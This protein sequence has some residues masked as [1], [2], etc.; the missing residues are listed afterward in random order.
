MTDNTTTVAYTRN[1]RGSQSLD[2]NE[3]ARAIWLWCLP[4]E[5]WL[6]VSHIPGKH[7]AVA[8][9]ASTSF[10]DSKKWKLDVDIFIKLSADGA[11]QTLICLPHD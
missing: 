4:R 8:D 2:C 3:I 6:T 11:N 9:R 1:M 5:I 10:D 7:N